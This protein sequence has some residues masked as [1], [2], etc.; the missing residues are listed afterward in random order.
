ML[1][2]ARLAIC[3]RLAL[4][5]PISSNVRMAACMICSRLASEMNVRFLLSMMHPSSRVFAEPT[6]RQSD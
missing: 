1:I 6:P 5:K 2:P 3:A 4:A